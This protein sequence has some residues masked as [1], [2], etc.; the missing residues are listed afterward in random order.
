MFW[1]VGWL[2][3]YGDNPR[4]PLGLLGCAFRCFGLQQRQLAL[5]QA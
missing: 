2:S 1:H 3:V 4:E 5:W